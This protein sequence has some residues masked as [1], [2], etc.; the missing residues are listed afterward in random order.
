LA[1]ALLNDEFFHSKSLTSGFY[2]SFSAGIRFYLFGNDGLRLEYDSLTHRGPG[3]YRVK[4]HR[5]SIGIP[6]K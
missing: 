4:G 3:N 5:I 2:S 1:V 6:L